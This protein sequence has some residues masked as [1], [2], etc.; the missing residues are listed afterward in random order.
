MNSWKIAYC[1]NFKCKNFEIRTVNDI[2]EHDFE[3]IDATVPGNFELDMMK[4]GKLPD[5]YWSENTLLAQKLENMHVWYFTEIELKEDDTYLHFDGI[6]TIA[7]IYIN[8]TFVKSHENMFIGFD[9]DQGLHI[10]NNEILVHIKPV[11]IESRKSIIPAS[12]TAMKYNYPSLY[13]RK[14]AHTFGWD[15][16][17][18]IITSGIWK[19]VTLLKKIPDKINEVFIYTS[20][21]SD[22]CARMIMYINISAEGDFITDYTVKVN[23]SC[24]DSSFGFEETMWHNTAS[25][26]FAVQSPKLWWPKNSG[27][28]NLYE[29]TVELFYKGELCDTYSLKT[30]IRTVKLN[31]SDTT[32][33][34]GNGEFCFEINNK[35][36]FVLGT[37]WV[38]L[39]AM[40]ANDINRVSK[41]L[42][43]L[44]DIGCNMVRCWGGN[45]YECDDFYNFC[46]EKGIL[47]WQDFA[48]GCAVYP[49]EKEFTE[50]LEEEAV[51]QIKRLR[52]HPAL[53]LWAGDN[54]CDDSYKGGRGIRRNPNEYTITREVLKRIVATHDITRPYLPSSPFTSDEAFKSGMPLPEEHLWGPRDY[55]KGSF[56]KNSVCHFAS[57][58]GYHGF[59]SVKSLRKFLKNPEI[60]FDEKGNPTAEYLVH[61]SGMEVSMKCPYAYRIRLAHNQVETLFGKAE[62]NLS[63][64]VKQSQISQAE[65]KKY[66]IERFRLSKWRRTGII[67]WNLIDGWPQVSDAVVD[68]YYTKKLAYSYIKR[69][70]QPV[71]LMFDEPENNKICLY[72]VNDLPENKTVSY[73]VT[74]LHT[75]TEVISGTV[76]VNADSSECIGFTDCNGTDKIFYLIEWW[77]N[78][79]KY[80]N[81]YFTN[82][83]DIDY[84]KYISAIT[85]CGFDQ[86]EEE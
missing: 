16:M 13:T 4:A 83:I 37:N 26:G 1:E 50:K 60:I 2:K 33:E 76:T 73:K 28:P 49:M 18:R 38:P 9:V 80:S 40:H 12:S 3:I 65:A 59:P 14:A 46:D 45:V 63:D 43:L 78:G 86:F 30:G 72:A 82:I 70:Q 57:E 8:G 23:G 71:C 19:P 7:D 62:E 32:D 5:L 41:A 34:D 20:S 11:C 29:T 21:I 64:F 36:I 22:D 15:I 54:E 53:V 69:S 35:K 74:N 75:N 58:T 51:Y 48:M 66:F 61:A 17:P 84:K 52:N 77:I 81:H 67:W 68:Y 55:F 39:D 85:Q 79:Q 27:E 44:D 25:I 47:I 10:G 24:V 42:E 56:Y 6:D 31:M